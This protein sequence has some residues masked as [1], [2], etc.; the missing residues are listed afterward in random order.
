MVGALLYTNIMYAL[1]ISLSMIMN[2]TNNLYIYMYICMY[3][4]MYCDTGN[5]KQRWDIIL[6]MLCGSGQ[7]NQCCT[8]YIN[9]VYSN[10]YHSQ[11]I[12]ICMIVK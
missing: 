9:M 11:L 12:L 1:L 6:L 4:L 5:Q 3:I 8:K 10:S 2:S 7:Y